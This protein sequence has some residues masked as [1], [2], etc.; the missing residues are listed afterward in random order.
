MARRDGFS[1]L[2]LLIVVAIIGILMAMY[3]STFGKVQRKAVAVAGAE[4]MRQ[5]QIGRMADD[6][7]VARPKIKLA[8]REECRAAFRESIGDNQFAT[9]MLYR[10]RNVEEFE[11]YFYTLIDAGAS[12]D[13]EFLHGRLVARNQHGNK[14]LL[15]PFSGFS[16]A[17][18]G[19][20]VSWE[21][22]STYMG[23][24]NGTG[25]GGQ[26]MYGDTRVEF[27]HYPGWFPMTERVAE[28]GRRFMIQAEMDS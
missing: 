14:F 12:G 8:T 2:E 17:F 27:M 5:G 16:E 24:M 26:V 20:A 28:L 1:L 3:L 21:F 15:S 9:R 13:L 22:L 6:A 11:A 4:G 25:I 18:G 7:N 19:T 23:D 10:V